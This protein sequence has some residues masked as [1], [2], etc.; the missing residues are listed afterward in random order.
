MNEV[1]QMAEHKLANTTNRSVVGVMNEFAFLAD[2]HRGAS[3]ELDLIGLSTTLAGTPC[4][5]LRS[6]PGLPDRELQALV[7]A[8]LDVTLGG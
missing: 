1:E 8:G 3:V 2:A 7:A 6:R 4:G 5:P